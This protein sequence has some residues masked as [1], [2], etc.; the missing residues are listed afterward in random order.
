MISAESVLNKRWM[1]LAYVRIESVSVH[2]CIRNYKSS[3]G[4]NSFIKFE[5]ISLSFFPLF[6]ISF[7]A[8]TNWIDTRRAS[9]EEAMEKKNS[10]TLTPIQRL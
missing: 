1:T 9:E 4:N 10:K 2:V 3:T 5:R 8:A 7:F 6:I